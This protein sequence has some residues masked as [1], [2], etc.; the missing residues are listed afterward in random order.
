MNNDGWGFMGAG[1]SDKRLAGDDLQQYRQP[2]TADEGSYP[3][4][5]VRAESEG[6]G[7]IKEHLDQEEA[8]HK[9]SA[10]QR[11]RHLANHLGRH[12]NSQHGHDTYKIRSK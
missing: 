8:R 4:R 5:R 9:Q 7:P 6:G 11:M 2:L 12:Y 10:E 3:Q 1:A